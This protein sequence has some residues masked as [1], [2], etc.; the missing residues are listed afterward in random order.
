M[1]LERYVKHRKKVLW[2]FAAFNP[3]FRRRQP[4]YQLQASQPSK[5]DKRRPDIQAKNEVV[6]RD[7]AM[8]DCR[9]ENLIYG[10]KPS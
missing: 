7:C 9:W 4:F 1:K 8:S 6:E 10:T 3:F 5:T 2:P